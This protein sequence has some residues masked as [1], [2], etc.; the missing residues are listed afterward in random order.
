M[1]T[2]RLFLH[3]SLMRTGNF[4]VFAVL[5]DCATCYLNS[6]R[7]QNARDLFVGQRFCR[8][9]IFNQLLHPALKDQKRSIASF[10]SVYALAEKITKLEN[11]LWSVRV[12]AGDCAADRGGMHTNLLRHFL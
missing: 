5:G 2:A 4:H 1:L 7:L 12:F 10:R 3:P 8:I 6:L 11:A 9:F